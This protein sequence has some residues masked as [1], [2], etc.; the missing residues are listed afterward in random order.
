MPRKI[1]YSDKMQDI[2][3]TV[4]NWIIRWGI[5]IIFITVFVILFMSY[6][7]KYPEVIT[8]PIIL[9]TVN[10]P[11]D[12]IS[13]TT[14]QIQEFFVYEGDTLNTHTIIA[15]I[16]NAANYKCILELDSILITYDTEWEKYISN[17]FIEHSYEL[18]EVQNS[19]NQFLTQ[20]KSYR[21]YLES[22]NILKKQQLLKE[23]IEQNRDNYQNQKIQLSLINEDLQFELQNFARDSALF[24][25]KAVSQYDYEKS[26]QAI[27][28][29]RMQLVGQ[30]SALSDIKTT[31]LGM[32]KQLLDLSI[33]LDDDLSNYKIHL[34][35]SRDLLLA[36]IKQW[37]ENYIIITPIDGTISLTKF[38]HK[39]QNI[40][41]GERIA[42]VI[43][44]DSTQIIGKMY[45]PSTGLAKVKIGQIVNIKLNG[46][47][48]MEFGILKGNLVS[49]SSVPETN[50]YA[51]EIQFPKGLISSYKTRFGFI[52]QMDG[53]GDI[54]TKDSRLIERFI[55]P[56]KSL[57]NNNIKQHPEQ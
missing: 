23:Q 11:A 12:L 27:L 18:G 2:M 24:N 13:K 10:P 52:Q 51:A 21:H 17:T 9:T 33:Q 39:N 53:T 32:E 38:W 36:Q 46:F 55:R 54:I 14:G 37:K 44:F 49:I 43:P 20:C 30:K 56:I 35:E 15:V 29:K 34:S 41:A 5:S 48:Y 7:I 50:G 26:K 40:I 8:A 42:T 4:P 19:F 25:A 16:K 31:I 47:P 57:I 22:N 1:I 28:Q 3:G 45:I 6:I